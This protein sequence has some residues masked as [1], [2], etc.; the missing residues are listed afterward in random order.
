MKT[1]LKRNYLVNDVNGAS[2][3]KLILLLYDGA[4]KFLKLS[5]KFIEDKKI[6]ECHNN[7]VKAENIIYNLTLSL[8]SE[9]GELANNLLKIYEFALWQLKEANRLKDKKKIIMV[10]N[11][12]G[13]LKN[14]WAK[15]ILY[16]KD[17]SEANSKKSL[18][19]SA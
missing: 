19:L 11:L 12:L 1:D 16:D 13:S 15:I 2:K 5:V 8:N 14:A 18:N 3:G 4:I 7:I 10:I 17:T 9:A 6:E